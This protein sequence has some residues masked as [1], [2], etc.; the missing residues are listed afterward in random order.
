MHKFLIIQEYKLKFQLF[1]VHN[2]FWFP[3]VD[4]IKYYFFILLILQNQLI[5]NYIRDQLTYFQVLYLCE[6]FIYFCNI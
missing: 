3:L 2:N 4:L 6:K 5:L 1:Q